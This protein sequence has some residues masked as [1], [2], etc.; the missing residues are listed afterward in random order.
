MK[1]CQ[2]TRPSA[3]VFVF[4]DFNVH[5][6]D[7]LTC[8]GGTDRPGELSYNIS[9]SNVLIQ[10]V[11]FPNQIP[12]SHGPALLGLF[13]PSDASICS[14]MAFPSLENVVVS[15]S[16]DFP[17]N[18]KQDVPFHRIAYNYSRANWDGLRDH[19]RDIP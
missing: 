10:M 7:W 6:K 5:H 3:N 9:I 4:R 13:L 1:F 18:S 16:I 17:I 14:T 11:N 2:S 12:G 19:L 15:V 8:S